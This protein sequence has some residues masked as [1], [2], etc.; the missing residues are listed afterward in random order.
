MVVLCLTRL[1]SALKSPDCLL[2]T[3][4]QDCA[5]KPDFEEG[6][7]QLTP[8]KHCLSALLVRSEA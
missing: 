7:S 4:S 3:D 1:S 2:Y 6:D 8:E 5:R